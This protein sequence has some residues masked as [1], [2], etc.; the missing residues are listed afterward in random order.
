MLLWGEEPLSLSILKSAIVFSFY[1][2]ALIATF[3][4]LFLC[5]MQ[6]SNGRR[7]SLFAIGAVFALFAVFMLL[8]LIINY[9]AV[10]TLGESLSFQWIYYADLFRSYTPQSAVLSS[11]TPTN[12]RVAAFAIAGFFVLSVVI[13]IFLTFI[14]RLVSLKWTASI[15]GCLVLMFLTFTGVRLDRSAEG[16]ARSANPLIELFRTGMAASAADFSSVPDPIDTNLT[17]RYDPIT[18]H[19]RSRIKDESMKNIVLIVMESVGA[20]YFPNLSPYD[21]TKF[22]PRLSE[23]SSRSVIFTNFYAH[24]PYSS[25]SMYAI[26]SGRYPRLSYEPD[27]AQHVGVQLPS[28]SSLLAERGFRTGL[29]M[30]GDLQFQSV[31]QFLKDKRFGVISDLRNIPC[32]RKLVGSSDEWTQSDAADDTC[33]ARA[34]NEW[35]DDD[36]TRPFLAMM[37]TGNTHHPYFP[38]V[39]PREGEFSAVERQNRYMASITR[40]D[41]AIG[42]VID[43][44]VARKLDDSTVVIVIGDHGESFGERGRWTHNVDVFDEQV[45]IPLAIFHPSIAGPI[46]LDVVGGLVDLPSTILDITRTGVVPGG[47]GRSM[48]DPVRYPRTFFFAPNQA[49]NVGFREGDDKYMLDMRDGVA[50]KFNL[51]SDPEERL[52]LATPD[53]EQFIRRV[54]AGW[55][56]QFPSDP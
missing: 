5:T 16:Y 15:L 37:W 17:R 19:A 11:L 39:E 24:A 21:T 10:R 23:L 41:E 29:F 4:A 28:I 2:V 43:H 32:D 52:N 50:R 54:L 48:F 3:A 53:T 22:A 6:M 51:A 47:H 30:S 55:Q 25:K 36:P 31:D 8:S 7:K 45:R 34:L 33:T 44:L 35:I 27:T 18:E 49:M 1:D 26:I 46:K 9:V 13:V 12:L 14:E 56:R 20:K 40:S 38:G 42:Y